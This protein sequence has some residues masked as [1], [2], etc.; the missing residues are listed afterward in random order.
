LGARNY[1]TFY[2]Q[3]KQ[4]RKKEKEKATPQAAEKV[5]RITD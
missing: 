5:L 2:L 1:A 3:K 4:N